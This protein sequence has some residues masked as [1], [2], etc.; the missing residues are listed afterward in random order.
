MILIS[1]AVKHATHLVLALYK[2]NWTFPIGSK[3]VFSEQSILNVLSINLKYHQLSWKLKKV[4]EKHHRQVCSGDTFFVRFV[5]F[6]LG[7]E[8]Y[9]HVS[10]STFVQ[11]YLCK[12]ESKVSLVIV[13]IFTQ[14][15]LKT[16]NARVIWK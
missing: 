4:F 16:C 3:S 11:C 10:I 7:T 9:C 14:N 6:C 1:T 8:W 15:C 13:F 5:I 12:E 2:I